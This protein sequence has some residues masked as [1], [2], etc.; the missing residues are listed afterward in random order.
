V[1]TLL[2]GW[3]LNKDGRRYCIDCGIEFDPLWE[4]NLSETLCDVC[5]DGDDD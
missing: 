4:G 3:E 1:R 5:D 2:K